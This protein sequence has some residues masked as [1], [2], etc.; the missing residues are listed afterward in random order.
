MDSP[1][2]EI[3]A[4]GDKWW[5]LGDN[6]HRTD[7]PAVELAS[8]SKQWYVEVVEKI[9][10]PTSSRNPYKVDQENA[11]INR[12]NKQT[13]QQQKLVKQQADMAF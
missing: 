1:R 2:I 13:A 6:L 10:S 11:K 9:I 8:G 3:D 7:G 4:R 5:Y 12:K